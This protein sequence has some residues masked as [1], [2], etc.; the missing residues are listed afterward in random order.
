MGSVRRVRCDDV[1][2]ALRAARSVPADAGLPL[3]PVSFRE[4]K[5][6]SDKDTSGLD[7]LHRRLGVPVPHIIERRE[8]SWGSVRAA[9]HLLGTLS[10][11]ERHRTV[12]RDEITRHVDELAEHGVTL[13]REDAWEAYR[14]ASFALLLMLVPPDREREDD[15]AHGGRAPQTL[16]LGA[17]MAIDPDAR[18]F[19]AG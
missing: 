8:R 5:D 15:P 18:E 7:R 14:Q 17:R 4:D 10:G 1:A 16:K 3:L 2:E 11:A 12:E 9:N 13:R 6:T 19:L